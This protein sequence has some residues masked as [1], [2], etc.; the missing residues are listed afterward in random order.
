MRLP[1]VT[2]QCSVG[3]RT[4]LPMWD[5]GGGSVL[6]SVWHMTRTLRSSA[7]IPHDFL[8]AQPRKKQNRIKI[9]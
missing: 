1:I 9:T 5:N 8:G 3:T 7:I 2:L 6:V 4:A